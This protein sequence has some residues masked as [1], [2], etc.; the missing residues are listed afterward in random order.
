MVW[1]P[2]NITTRMRGERET[3][4]EADDSTILPW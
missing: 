4:H 1:S 3:E 2:S